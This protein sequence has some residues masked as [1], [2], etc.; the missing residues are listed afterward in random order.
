MRWL[1]ALKHLEDAGFPFDLSGGGTGD[2][3]VSGVVSDSRKVAPGCVFCCV[4]GERSDGHD[5]AASARAS[6]AA[7]L[8]CERPVDTDLPYILVKSTRAV[9]GELAAAVYSHPA[10][11]LL[12]VGVTGTNG[13]S[14]T[15]YIMRSILQAAGIKTG[16]LG[17]IIESDGV[18]ERDAS[19]TTP[20]SC[21]VQAMLR[22]MVDNG[23][24]ACVMETSSHGLA[25]GRLFGSKFDIAVFTNLHPEHLDFHGDMESYFQAKRLL[26][27]SFM[28]EGAVIAANSDDPYGRRLLSELP[29]SSLSLSQR[30]FGI[31]DAV[32]LALT[33]SGASFKL[34]DLAMESPLFG[35]FNVYNVLA[36]ATALSGF[37]PDEAIA[38]GVRRVPQVPGRMERHSLPNGAC[39]LVDFAHTPEALRSVLTAARDIAGGRLI[40]VFGHGGGRYKENRPALGRVAASLADMVIV[41]SDNPRDEDPAA[42]AGAIVEGIGTA[43]HKVI[44]NRKEAVFTALDIAGPGDVVVLSGKGPEKFLLVGDKKIPYSDAETVEEWAR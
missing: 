38:L 33:Q 1:E 31:A 15:T 13:K 11:R 26:F 3:D 16:L 9:M 40:S 21:D 24:G 44:L 18:T 12:M 6:G 20:E 8:V 22:A 29:S 19:R 37:V 32:G 41:T 5:Y 23:C 39:C 34:A 28:K 30:G 27:T 7:A 4:S 17:T 35:R 43:P 36:A 2:A 42:I 10:S 14:T 25:L